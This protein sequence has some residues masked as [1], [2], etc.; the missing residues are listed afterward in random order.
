MAPHFGVS[1]A[2]VSKQPLGDRVVYFQQQVPKVTEGHMD[3]LKYRCQPPKVGF[4]IIPLLQ[5]MG[6]AQGG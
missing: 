6:E 5:P 2:G 1:W 4:T 3:P